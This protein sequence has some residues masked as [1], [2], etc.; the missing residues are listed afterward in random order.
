MLRAKWSLSACRHRPRLLE[1]QS[2]HPCTDI[3]TVLNSISFLYFKSIETFELI[4]PQLL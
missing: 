1:D 4:F 3:F 2:A